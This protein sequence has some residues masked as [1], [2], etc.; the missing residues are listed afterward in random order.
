MSSLTQSQSKREVCFSSKANSLGGR[1]EGGETLRPLITQS[2]GPTPVL[3][4]PVPPKKGAG[5][6]HGANHRTRF[7]VSRS[8]SGSLLPMLSTMLRKWPGGPWSQEQQHTSHQKPECHD[9]QG[10]GVDNN[11]LITPYSQ[12][13]NPKQTHPWKRQNS[14]EV[15]IYTVLS[16]KQSKIGIKTLKTTKA[17]H[18]VI[19]LL[20]P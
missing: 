7:L 14:A 5:G 10:K 8:G 4:S 11:M 19:L 16:E 17:S 18:L 12:W 6:F 1:W 3:K 9:A 15:D 2:L 13:S 20:R